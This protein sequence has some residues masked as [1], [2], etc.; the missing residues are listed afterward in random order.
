MGTT[1]SEGKF[2]L[3]TGGNKGVAVGESMV[4]ITAAGQGTAAP[5]A[6]L[7][8]PKQGGATAED[9]QAKM[10]QFQEMSKSMMQTSRPDA[11]TAKPKSPIPEKYSN[12]GSSGLKQTVD[13][14]RSKNQFVIELAD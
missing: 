3:F 7:G 6:N 10:K 5:P 8:D 9:G 11:S 1:D 4:A 12:G 13:S 2:T 14:D